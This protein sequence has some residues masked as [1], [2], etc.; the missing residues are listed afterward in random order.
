MDGYI[1]IIEF[2]KMSKNNLG[3]LL[4]YTGQTTRDPEVRFM[5]HFKNI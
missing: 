5:E 4:Y 1:Y 3:K 2:M